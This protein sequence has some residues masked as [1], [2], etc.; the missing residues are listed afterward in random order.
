MA[1]LDGINLVIQEK[2][3]RTAR[4]FAEKNIPEKDCTF[5]EHVSGS[6]LKWEI[7]GVLI[8]ANQDDLYEMEQALQALVDGEEKTF[9]DDDGATFSVLVEAVETT[10]QPDLPLQSRY[11]IR[12]LQTEVMI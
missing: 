1:T 7:Q 10:R 5:R 2:I 6:G 3:R 8:A 4:R 12:F 11:S 9:T